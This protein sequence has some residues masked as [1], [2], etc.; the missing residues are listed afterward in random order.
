MAVFQLDANTL[1]RIK[2]LCNPP[3]I[4]QQE[5]KKMRLKSMSDERQAKWPNTLAAQRKRKEEERAKRMEAEHQ[6]RVELDQKERARKAQERQRVVERANQIMYQQT[7]NMKQLRSAQFLSD[8]LHDRHQQ[9][10]IKDRIA[11][12]AE[13]REAAWHAMTMQQVE[14]GNAKEERVRSRERAKRKMIASVQKQQVRQLRESY[15]SKLRE[16]QEEGELI[17]TRAIAELEKEKREN[18]KKKWVARQAVVALKVE[19]RQAVKLKEQETLRIAAE[20]AKIEAFATRKERLKSDMQTRRDQLAT[21]AMQRQ[22]KM[23]DRAVAHLAQLKSDEDQ[24]LDA[25]MAEVRAREDAKEEQRLARLRKLNA[26]IDASRSKQM[27][28]RRKRKEDDVSLAKQL[29]ADAQAYH[30]QVEAEEKAEWSMQRRRAKL[31][32]EFLWEQMAENALR[33]AAEQAE[34]TGVDT[35]EARIKEET[36]LFRQHVEASISDAKQSG[37]NAHPLMSLLKKK[38][39][40]QSFD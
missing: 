1:R 5:R 17:A 25:Q 19:N 27:E 11:S 16:E 39:T 29:L 9:I 34:I 36:M 7:D 22:Q 14:D 2:T 30:A 20:D 10:E 38:Q 24:R 32:Q 15:I 26:T 40:L 35:S 31:H 28:A 3:K 23:I 33:R 6:H 8:V 18:E 13:K 4:T 12:M 21:E 37:K